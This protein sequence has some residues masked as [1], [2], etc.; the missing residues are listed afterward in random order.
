MVNCA[1]NT[2]SLTRLQRWRIEIKY[3]LLG[4]LI[5]AGGVVFSHSAAAS[6]IAQQIAQSL[7]AVAGLGLFGVFA[8]AL[9]ANATVGIHIPYTALMLTIAAVYDSLTAKLLLAVASGLGASTGEFVSYAVAYQLSGTLHASALIARLYRLIARY[10][11]LTPLAV[12]VGAVSPLP[13]D[14]II[15][16]LALAKYPLRKILVPMF[17]GKILHNVGLI[18]L[19]EFVAHTYSAAP[20]ARFDLSLGV[21]LFSGLIVLYQLEKDQAAADLAP[22]HAPSIAAEL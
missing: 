10:P 14:V 12:F 3:V 8:G 4:I 13:D 9:I 18:F 15:V 16:P 1:Q 21:L 7:Q 5:L 11:H 6:T 19:F 2:H 22:T 17:S 20:Q